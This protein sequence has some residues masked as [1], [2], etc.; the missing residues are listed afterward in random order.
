MERPFGKRHCD[1]SDYRL[2]IRQAYGTLVLLLLR[3]KRS[4]FSINIGRVLIKC[5]S[6]VMKT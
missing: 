6:N 4:W 3:A 2:L 1:R 5:T